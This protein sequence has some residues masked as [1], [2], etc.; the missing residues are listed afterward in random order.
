MLSSKSRSAKAEWDLYVPSTQLFLK[1]KVN[2]RTKAFPFTL[3]LDCSMNDLKNSSKE[4]DEGKNK[5]T[6]QNSE[7]VTNISTK[8]RLYFILNVNKQT[9]EEA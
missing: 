9:K 4:K 1:G 5:K 8:W 3:M 6:K 7:L 2:G